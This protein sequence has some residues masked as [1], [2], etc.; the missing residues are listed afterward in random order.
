M[1]H[2]RDDAADNEPIQEVDNVQIGDVVDR[3]G[4]KDVESAFDDLQTIFVT[5]TYSCYATLTNHSSTSKG[6][7]IMECT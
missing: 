1:L 5:K 7:R 2:E 6:N 3:V 4:L